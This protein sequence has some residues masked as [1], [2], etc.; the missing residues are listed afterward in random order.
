ME[1]GGWESAETYRITRFLDAIPKV[2][3]KRKEALTHEIHRREVVL[4]ALSDAA[5][6]SKLEVTHFTLLYD[7]KEKLK[8]YREEP[9]AEH[10]AF[11][12]AEGAFGTF[13][14]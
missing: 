1:A 10:A 8:G 14:L 4:A 3:R 6:K 5:V 7:K 9:L 13:F 12:V 2:V 11:D